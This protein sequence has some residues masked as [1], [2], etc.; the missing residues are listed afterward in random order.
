MADLLIFEK[1]SWN[2]NQ[3]LFIIY[4]K[5][6]IW[7]NYFRLKNSKKMAGLLI[8]EKNPWNVNQYL[9]II[10]SK[11]EIWFNYFKLRNSR[12][13]A[14]LLIFEKN[15]NLNESIFIYNLLETQNL[16]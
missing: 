5:L 6:E 10:Y 12:K 2:V 14:D 8:F 9:F 15:E 3:Y 1:N 11:L 16:I 4:S 7:F 13:I